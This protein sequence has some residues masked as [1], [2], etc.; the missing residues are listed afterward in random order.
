MS[1]DS[2]QLCMQMPSA[3][4]GRER[5]SMFSGKIEEVSNRFAASPE[6]V[7]IEAVAGPVRQT[8][9]TPRLAILRCNRFRS[10]RTDHRVAGV[11][12]DSHRAAL[13]AKY[14]DEILGLAAAG[15]SLSISELGAGT[16]TRT[17]LLLQ[18]AVRRQ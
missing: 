3:P 1:A 9:G 17:G 7:R 5:I 8:K 16:A 12:S 6:A 4:R 11:L 2:E 14:S 10:F 13:L 18:S 15:K